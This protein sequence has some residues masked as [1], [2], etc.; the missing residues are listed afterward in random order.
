MK[1]R[2]IL[3]AF[4]PALLIAANA[5]CAQ[6]TNIAATQ[7]GQDSI[8]Y[9]DNITFEDSVVLEDGIG[10]GDGFLEFE[11][12]M[13]P[14]S[15]GANRFVVTNPAA[16]GTQTFERNGAH[17][18]YSNSSDGYIMVKYTAND[19]PT[20][21]AKIIGPSGVAYDYLNIRSDGTYDIFPLTDGGGSYRF[22]LGK[23]MPDGRWA[24]IMNESF[25]V[26]LADEFA[27][28]LRPNTMVDFRTAPNTVA[29]AAELLKGK[30]GLV[31]QISAVYSY[32]VEN[33]KYDYDLAASITA[34]RS[35][36]PVLDVSLA[37]GK[38]VCY[39]YAV[40]MTA[41]LRSQGVPIRLVIGYQGTVYHAWIDAYSDST[42]WINS[43]VRF[44]GEGW[45]LL[46]PTYASTGG[47]EGMKL[48]N[49]PKNYVARFLY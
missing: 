5:G 39:D 42:G 27:P 10:L 15:A 38:G 14:L 41:M 9:E 32:L 29:K 49:N 24:Q 48:A 19:A 17:L 16:P 28:F 1:A 31:E 35:Y 44:E 43:I 30:T 8:P 26:K 11:A 23:L 2:Q 40:L 22:A 4:M 36:R 33:F 13:T 6:E 47:E 25:A 20:I 45:R 18:D 12:E 37:N 7:N 3:L 34:G 21:S 46:D